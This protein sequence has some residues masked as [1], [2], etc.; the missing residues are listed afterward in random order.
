MFFNLC[1]AADPFTSFLCPADPLGVRG[2][3]A[4]I[5]CITVKK[6]RNWIVYRVNSLHYTPVHPIYLSSILILFP[7]ISHTI[8]LLMFSGQTLQALRI[9]SIRATCTAHRV[10]F[11]CICREREWNRYINHINL[12]FHTL[13]NTGYEV[14]NRREETLTWKKK[15]ETKNYTNICRNSITGW[16]WNKTLRC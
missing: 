6:I 5:L 9:S 2:P 16:R 7:H 8:L 15:I 10:H 11:N 3:Q 14:T 12:F 13:T 4:E 1:G